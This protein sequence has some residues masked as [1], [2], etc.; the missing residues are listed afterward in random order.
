MSPPL[1][2]ECAREFDKVVHVDQNHCWTYAPVRSITDNTF[3]PKPKANTSF[4]S[5]LAGFKK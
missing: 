3:R 5:L 4:A 1:R 2:S